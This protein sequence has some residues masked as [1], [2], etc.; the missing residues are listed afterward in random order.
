[1]RCDVAV[2]GGGIAG[3]SAALAAVRTGAQRV[4]LLEKQYALG[5]LATL[6]LIAI[7]LPLCDGKGRQVSFGISEELLRLSVSHGAPK[8]PPLMWLGAG[9]RES[10]CKQRFRAQYDPNVFAILAE[11]L[12]RREGV[13]ILYGAGV[14]AADCAE[15]RI[16]ALI[17][18]DADGRWAVETGRVIDAS[19]DAVVCR[20]A[21]AP[22]QTYGAGNLLGAWY[23]SHDESA[24]SMHI[25]GA[26]DLP[27]DAGANRPIDGASAADI[28]RSV[29][30]MHDVILRDFLKDGGVSPMHGL[31]AIPGIPLIRMS[32][33]LQGAYTL[34]EAEM[35]THFPDSIGQIANWKKAG[36]VYELPFRILYNPCV[37]NLAAAGRCVSV[38]DDM[39]DLTRVI[40]A[41]A[42]TGEAAGTAAALTDDF[43]ALDPALLRRQLCRSGVR[44]RMELPPV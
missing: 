32:R 40:P 1:M 36:P 15:G 44:C 28:N 43:S 21:G 33:R 7:Y 6:G 13:Q 2:V 16:R 23:Y 5:G 12:L 22:T 38:S 27:E 11:Q 30:L 42:V 4:L 37:K 29:M 25:F 10:R 14:C 19:G 24:L 26:G 8:E 31:A 18:E 9:S 20:A 34:H 17:V 3:I 41:C 35:F 39:W